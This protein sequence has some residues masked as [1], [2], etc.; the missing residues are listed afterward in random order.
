MEL[1]TGWDLFRGTEPAA[2]AARLVEYGPPA[3]SLA[4]GALTYPLAAAVL[5]CYAATAEANGLNGAEETFKIVKFA[6][7]AGPHRLNFS[8]TRA[9]LSHK[10][11]Y[12]RLVLR[13]AAEF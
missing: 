1:W 11:G 6:R 2:M 5:T 8:L 10:V 7:L 3:A 12:L 4:I 13:Q 9:P